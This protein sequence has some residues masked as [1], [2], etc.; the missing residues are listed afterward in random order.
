MGFAVVRPTV[1]A[2]VRGGLKGDGAAAQ[3]GRLRSELEAHVA[4]LSR[5]ATEERVSFNG[6]DG[7]DGQRRLKPGAPV[8][9]PFVRHKRD[10]PL[11]AM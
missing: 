4:R 10:L 3:R 8:H 5:V 9:G 2:G 7:W 6:P 11:S 1:I